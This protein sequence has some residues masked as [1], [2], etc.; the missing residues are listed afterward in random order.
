MISSPCYSKEGYEVYSTVAEKP[1]SIKKLL[2]ELGQ[3]GEVR[4]FSIKNGLCSGTKTD[5]YGL[6]VKQKQAVA[7]A[8]SMGYYSWP[9]KVNLEEL[10]ER[11][12]VKRRTLQENLRKAEGKILP[13]LLDELTKQ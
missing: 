13:R 11:L 5:R 1:G 9:K 2:S 10:A 3:I 12:G 7:A 6:T 4:I 8:I